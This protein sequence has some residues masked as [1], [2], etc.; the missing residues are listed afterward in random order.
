MNCIN[1]FYKTCQSDPDKP[2]LWINGRTL[3]FKELYNLSGKAQAFCKSLGIQKGDTVLLFDNV[4]FRL[5]AFIIAILALG[6]NIIFIEPWMSPKKISSIIANM[7]PKFFIKNASG[8]LWSFFFQSVRAIPY[9]ADMK[10]FE[11]YIQEDLFIVDVN[12]STLAITAFTTGTTGTP[13]RVSR[14]QDYLTSQFEMINKYFKISEYSGMALCVLPGFV[15]A[16]LAAGRG[17]I[18]M[19]S[20]WKKRELKQISKLTGALTP[21]TLICGPAFLL[22]LIKCDFSFSSLVS[23]H[24]G[25]ALTDLWILEK[26]FEKWP[27]ASIVCVYGSSE[28]EPVALCDAKEV[29]LKSKKR[30]F[31]QALYLG[32][33]V[34]EIKYKKEKGALLV[35][36]NH[37]LPSHKINL[38]KNKTEDSQ[39]G[40]HCMGDRIFLDQ[41][42][43]WYYGRSNQPEEDFLLEQKIYSRL[44]SSKSF[45]TVDKGGR[46][47]LWGE[48]IDKAKLGDLKDLFF[49]I[50]N[51]KI[52]R[53]PRH[54]SRIDRKKSMR[55]V[56][57]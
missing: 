45:I 19:S 5:Y 34:K 40:W 7:K 13:K 44:K 3:T 29:I 48:N 57:G 56:Y 6:A 32:K 38:L 54:K 33:P 28:A 27:E 43:W 4:G 30:D 53:D 21:T 52:I 31:F 39:K 55:K 26:G 49:K 9:K 47:Y 24:I 14:Q 50:K 23:F 10:R 12:S 1:L 20:K 25:G 16:N 2:A 11:G 8:A 37:V 51:V 41:E 17:S 35:K 15:F 22:K 36:G 18:L 46:K 42:G